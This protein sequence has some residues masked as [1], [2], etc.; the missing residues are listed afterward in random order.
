MLFKLSKLWILLFPT[1]SCQHSIRSHG[2]EHSSLSVLADWYSPSVCVGACMCMCVCVHVCMCAYMH[3]CAW[4]S[5]C[6]CVGAHVCGHTCVSV[7]S[8]CVFVCR[9]AYVCMRLCLCVF[10]F[11]SSVLEIVWS[12][13]T[14]GVSSC[15]H[16]VWDGVHQAS[17]PASLQQ[18]SC[19]CLPPQH[20]SAGIRDAH[21][22]MGCYVGSGE[23]ELRWLGLCGKHGTHWVIAPALSLPFESYLTTVC[24]YGASFAVSPKN[25]QSGWQQ[26]PSSCLWFMW[27]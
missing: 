16:L 23:S 14:S 12:S 4:V 15:P 5:V 2:W 22:T 6:M 18:F 21:Y 3:V 10:L 9:C 20:R 19:L 7:C 25:P 11:V 26:V 8:M 27:L 1:W 17:P 24:W 13:G